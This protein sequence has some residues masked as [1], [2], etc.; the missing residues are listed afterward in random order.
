LSILLG[1]D[2]SDLVAEGP[3]PEERLLDSEKAKIR[4]AKAEQVAAMVFGR[5]AGPPNE[6]ITYLFCRSLDYKPARVAEERFAARKLGA[7]G[8]KGAPAPPLDLELETQWAEK[9]RLPGLRISHLLAPLRE[10]LQ[11]NLCD[12]PLHGATRSLYSGTQIWRLPISEGQ[13]R[14]YFRT[15]PATED[16]RKWCVNVQKRM[17]KSAIER[18]D[19]QA[20]KG[21]AQ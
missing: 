4:S 1:G 18:R 10:D 3:N 13:L 12:Y 15:Q 9:S 20:P 14:Q 16:I 21:G 8:S 11:L 2:G 19:S 5:A 7:S 6:R 17:V